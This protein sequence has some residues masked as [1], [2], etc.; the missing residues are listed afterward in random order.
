MSHIGKSTMLLYWRCGKMVMI[1]FCLLFL[2]LLPAGRCSDIIFGQGLRSCGYCEMIITTAHEWPLFFIT[3]WL[4]AHFCVRAAETP[5]T[6]TGWEWGPHG[7]HWFNSIWQNPLG[8]AEGERKMEREREKERETWWKRGERDASGASS[9]N[10]GYKVKAGA[11]GIPPKASHA[12]EW[13]QGP[14]KRG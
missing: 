6:H 5:H 4:W 1:L 7:P 9:A 10:H 12:R 14:L 11:F 2:W 13:S 8:R 3:L